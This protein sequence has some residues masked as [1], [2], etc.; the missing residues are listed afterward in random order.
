MKR[1]L[2]SILISVLVLMTGYI[3]IIEVNTFF[4]NKKTTK[5]TQE[6]TCC[7][8]KKDIDGCLKEI[9]KR[10]KLN[11]CYSVPGSVDDARKLIKELGSLGKYVD[12]SDKTEEIGFCLNQL[13]DSAYYKI[14]AQ[15]YDKEEYKSFSP[16]KVI[17]EQ[18][19][20]SKQV[21]SI[22][23][24]KSRG[25]KIRHTKKLR[26]K[27]FEIIAYSKVQPPLNP[28]T[29][30]KVDCGEYIME[31]IIFDSE[32]GVSVPGYLLIPKHVSFPAPAIIALHQHGG[33]HRFGAD[34]VVGIAGDD[35]TQFYAKELAQ[36]GYI[37]LA[38]DARCFG[39]RIE[40]DEELVSFLGRLIGKNLLGRI[41]WDDLRSIDYLLTRKEVDPNRIGCIGHSMG[42]TRA[43]YL[44]A[45]DDR[46][47]AAVVSGY[48]TSYKSLVKHNQV[49]YPPTT[50]IPEILKYAEYE[51]ILS[52]IA[53]RPLLIIGGREDESVP[54]DGELDT[55]KSLR[56]IYA[57]FEAEDRLDSIIFRGE[58]GFPKDIHEEAYQWLDKWLKKDK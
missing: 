28:R 51:D 45:L 12:G 16:L 53:P 9:M 19:I 17:T 34:G 43:T 10:H 30:K 1:V 15:D 36:R 50:C 5:K 13:L 40:M 27:I 22:R 11:Y 55:Y 44:A 35:Q 47:K 58:H 20:N 3:F 14:R 56:K 42:G 18:V 2:V 49:L 4:K 39:E 46:I 21:M 54:I 37:T 26:T 57:L 7:S 29:I 6:E 24:I 23:S 48:I 31:K 38:M 33:Q 25:G 41:V 52:L 8:N 32:P